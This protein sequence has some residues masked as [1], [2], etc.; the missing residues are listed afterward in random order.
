MS[1]LNLSSVDTR[2]RC[3]RITLSAREHLA[4][5]IS[6]SSLALAPDSGAGTL[7]GVGIELVEV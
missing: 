3:Q 7:G 5:L 6:D 1:E 4:N 2:V